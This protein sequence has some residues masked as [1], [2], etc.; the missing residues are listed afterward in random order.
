MKKEY[1]APQMEV[2]KIGITGMLCVSGPLGNPATDPAKAP[3]F[4][5]SDK[6]FLFGDWEID[7]V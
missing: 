1:I 2:V 4:D 5:W 3:E 7:D 6:A